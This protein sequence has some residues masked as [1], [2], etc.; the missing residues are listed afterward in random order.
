MKPET[1]RDVIRALPCDGATTL[2]FLGAL[3]V[4]LLDAT[5]Y[6][7]CPEC[8]GSRKVPATE[9]HYGGSGGGCLVVGGTKPCP[10]CAD[11]PT[12]IVEAALRE[13]VKAAFREVKKYQ[14]HKEMTDSEAVDLLLSTVLGPVRYAK[15]I[16]KTLCPSVGCCICVTENQLL[17]HKGDTIAILED[18]D[19]TD[20]SAAHVESAATNRQEAG[21]ESD[22]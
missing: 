1:L 17:L 21:K 12:A 22:K 11:A 10:A 20:T 13:K 8:G 3:P 15:G 2:A 4:A 16:V 19:S 18:V 9:A 7:S 6:R 5:V 14:Q